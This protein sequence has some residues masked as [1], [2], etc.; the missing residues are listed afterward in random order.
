VILY[1]AEAATQCALDAIQILGKSFVF[2]F[3][4]SS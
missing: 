2:N 3:A 1:T 4:D